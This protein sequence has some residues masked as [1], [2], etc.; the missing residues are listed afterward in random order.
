MPELRLTVLIGTYA[1]K[2]YLGAAAKKNL[3]ETVRA[4][5]D[6]GP[7]LRSLVAAAVSEPRR[8]SLQH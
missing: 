3:T 4:Y 2:H 1:Q 6:Y 7:A 5:R 8:G